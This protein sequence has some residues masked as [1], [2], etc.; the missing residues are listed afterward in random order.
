[1]QFLS[2]LSTSCKRENDPKR[3][4][5]TFKGFVKMEPFIFFSLLNI[6]CRGRGLFEPKGQSFTD[7]FEFPDNSIWHRENGSIICTTNRINAC[8]YMR[9]DNLHYLTLEDSEMTQMLHEK[10]RHLMAIWLM[11]DCDESHCCDQKE[12]CTIFSSGML[13]SNKLYSYGLFLFLARAV[14]HRA[15][16]PGDNI[17]EARTCFSLQS[18]NFGRK[19]ECSICVSTENPSKALLIWRYHKD[20]WRRY[21]DLRYNAA[22]DL[23]AFGFDWRPD[24]LRY[25]VEKE[26][27]AH[28]AGDFPGPVDGVRLVV[29]VLPR[30]SDI[31]PSPYSVYMSTDIYRIAYNKHKTKS[32]HMDLFRVQKSRNLVPTFV[33]LIFILVFC[34][35][36]RWFKNDTVNSYI[37]APNDYRLLC[38]SS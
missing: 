4:E 10:Q 18:D 30:P 15:D 17:V 31:A 1:L 33:I 29:S 7:L 26:V 13:I 8:A 35:V 24:G 21:V 16:A 23:V 38:E 34:I 20:S 25:Y 19:V 2:S 27:L 14:P 22:T 3:S 36:A 32:N 11:N 9:S 28:V 6:I 5:R 37:Q 12:R